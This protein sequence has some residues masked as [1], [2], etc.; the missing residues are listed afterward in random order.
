MERA[1]AQNPG[2]FFAV[3]LQRGLSALW[4]AALVGA[5]AAWIKKGE[6][7]APRERRRETLTV[8]IQKET[9]AK[10]FSFSYRGRPYDVKP[11]AEYELS[12]IVVS[13]N[14]ISSIA[15]L[16]H[17]EDSVDTVDACL[18]WGE[19]AASPDL[20]R[21]S[22]SNGQFTC[23]FKW[24]GDVAFQPKHVSNNHLVTDR[25]ALREKI[26]ALRVGDQV[27]LSGQ[28]VSYR[29]A[30]EPDHWRASSLTRDDTDNGACEVVFVRSL[31][32]LAPGTPGWYALWRACALLLL[33][34]PALKA[35]LA[36]AGR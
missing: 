30:D 27:R 23:Y 11:L 7:P 18:A 3:T 1:G 33:A 19:A 15:D 4:L 2:S 9:D 24:S 35:A 34:V 22:F 13:R 29:P 17:D 10:P 36:F 14:D 6:L 20:D 31:D 25:P 12:G 16:M 21:V 32:V 28:L 26:G 5:G 8:P